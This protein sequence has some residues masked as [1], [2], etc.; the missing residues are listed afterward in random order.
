MRLVLIALYKYPYLLT[1]LSFFI[2]TQR[3]L[4]IKRRIETQQQNICKSVNSS[5]NHSVFLIL[6]PQSVEFIMVKMKQFPN[7]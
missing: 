6:R 3:R 4:H 7:G 2:N 5:V 1:Y